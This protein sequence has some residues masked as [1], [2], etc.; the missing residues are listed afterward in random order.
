MCL[1]FFTSKETLWVGIVFTILAS[2]GFW[3]SIVFYNAYLPEVAEPEDHDR[4]SAK[5]FMLGYAGSV[6]LLAF[7]LSMV[8]KPDLYG[9][10]DSTLP[11]RISFLTVGI[12]WFGFAQITYSRLPNNVYGH[13]PEK[14]YIWKGFK[15][16]KI[17]GNEIKNYPTL[18]RFLY[19][20]F[21]LSVGVQTI[22]LLA[23]IFGST[24]LGLGTINLIV[25]VLLIQVVAIFGAWFFSNLSHKYGNFKATEVLPIE[26]IDVAEYL[27]VSKYV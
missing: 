16:L 1:F 17:V 18:K 21:S 3:G 22:I 24:E 25:T 4:V 15:E 10:T 13:K 23:T 26:N 27:C 9:I 6:L 8:M 19:A 12:W 11:A 7:N 5:G 14:D 20:F 2:I